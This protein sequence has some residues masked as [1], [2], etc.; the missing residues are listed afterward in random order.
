MTKKEW[1]HG[2]TA[3]KIVIEMSRIGH[4]SVACA[5]QGEKEES[6]KYKKEFDEK[7]ES[8]V[9]AISDMKSEYYQVNPET[10]G[11]WEKCL[12]DIKSIKRSIDAELLEIYTKSN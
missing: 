7:F 6:N 10:F 9:P 2:K 12:S 1:F 3:S 4:E 5:I 11:T 8:V